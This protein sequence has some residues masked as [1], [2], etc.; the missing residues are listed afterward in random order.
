MRP[1]RPAS[2]GRFVET[3]IIDPDDGRPLRRR[4]VSKLLLRG[5]A[6]T[7]QAKPREQEAADPVRVLLKVS[8]QLSCA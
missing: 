3:T 7:R 5:L 4:K 2:D 6:L 8:S 1:P